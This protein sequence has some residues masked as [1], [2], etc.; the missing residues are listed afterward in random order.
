LHFLHAAIIAF[1]LTKS[2]PYVEP[3]AKI[4]KAGIFAFEVKSTNL[5]LLALI[6]R[7]FGFSQRD[8][9][10]INHPTPETV[11]FPEKKLYALSTRSTMPYN[12]TVGYQ[13]TNGFTN[14]IKCLGANR[15]IEK[16]G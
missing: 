2:Y 16:G 6:R 10:V 4:K 9:V 14:Q 12:K 7:T 11:I 15:R 8:T 3:T 13:K 1:Y 5:A